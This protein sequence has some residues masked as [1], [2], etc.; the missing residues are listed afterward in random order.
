MEL[1]GYREREFKN[2]FLLTVEIWI[3]EKDISLLY[4]EKLRREKKATDYCVGGFL[5]MTLIIWWF[6]YLNIYL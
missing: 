1:H 6:F 3:E 4:N 2:L 5:F